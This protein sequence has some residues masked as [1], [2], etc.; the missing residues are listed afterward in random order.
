MYTYVCCS[1]NYNSQDVGK[2]GTHTYIYMHTYI[3]WDIIQLLKGMKYLHLQ[4]HG[5]I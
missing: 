5:W 1:T 4:Q 3:Q 2:K